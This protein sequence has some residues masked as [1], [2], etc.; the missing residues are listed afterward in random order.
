[1]AKRKRSVAL[2]EVIQKDKR[3]ARSGGALPTP[4]WMEKGKLLQPITQPPLHTTPA[5]PA[6][7]Q[8]PASALTRNTPSAASFSEA[9]L[10]GRS[11]GPL[12]YTS[13]AII[14]A[15]VILVAAA[16]VWM[17]IAHR[18][19]SGIAE[20]QALLSGPAHPQVLDVPVSRPPVRA[21]AP[22][23]AATPAAA[24]AQPVARQVNVSYVRI[25]LY[26]SQQSA[27]AARDLLTQ[28]GV[29]CTVE[30]GIPGI[31]P[32]LFAVVGMT[33]FAATDTPE[34]TAYIRQIKSIFGGSRPLAPRLIK[35]QIP[36]QTG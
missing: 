8:P 11:Q 25:R 9:V 32:P 20:A 28:H 34:Y 1:M 10:G 7:P 16:I 23:D 24:S 36:P 4:A 15:A 18:A 6:S 29:P 35:W 12:T 21:D 5:A 3:F 26:D 31:S 2:F 17:S 27:A 22:L 33:A 14:A 13:I 30:H 19:A